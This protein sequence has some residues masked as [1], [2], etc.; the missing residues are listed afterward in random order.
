MMDTIDVS[1]QIV[2]MLRKYSDSLISAVIVVGLVLASVAFSILLLLQVTRLF[3]LY[4][5][6]FPLY[7]ALFP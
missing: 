3:L 2:D 1:L 5:A 7:N 6:L 4:N